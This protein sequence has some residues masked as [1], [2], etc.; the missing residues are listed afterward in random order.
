MSSRNG[1]QPFTV[2]D[3][4][5]L[6]GLSA[7]GS[8]SPTLP[9]NKR[10]RVRSPSVTE[11][12]LPSPRQARGHHERDPPSESG[13][14]EPQTDPED[15]FEDADY[16]GEVI[17]AI[18]VKS[19][20]TVGCSF[21]VA[22][23]EKLFVSSDMKYGGIEMVEACKYRAWLLASCFPPNHHISRGIEMI[24]DG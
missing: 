10:V 2:P 24:S 11:N 22:R 14:A 16:L 19:N 15:R 6:T 1:R 4:R 7:H 17:T 3:N 23:E 21:Y 18:Q 8:Q 9:V 20:D 5:S 13:R 12:T